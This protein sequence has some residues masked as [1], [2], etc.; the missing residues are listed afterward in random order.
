MTFVAIL[1]VD[2]VG[3]RPL[4]LTG[5]VGMFV[6]AGCMAHR[7]HPAE[8]ARR[9]RDAAGTVGRRSH[10]SAR[11][12]FVIFFGASWGPLVWVLLGRDVPEPHPGSRARCADGRPVDRELPHHR[13]LPAAARRWACAFI[14]GLF[15]FFAALSFFFVMTKIPETKG[16][17]LEDMQT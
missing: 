16:M 14:Y 5:S 6:G 15:A 9:R 2:K 17:E 8:G 7:V 12:L 10:W 11:T 13:C 4:L 3:R 1:L